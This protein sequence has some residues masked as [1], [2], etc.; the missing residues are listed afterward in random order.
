EKRVNIRAQET[1]RTGQRQDRKERCLGDADAGIGGGELTL[2]SGDVRPALEQIGGQTGG[3]NRRLRIPIGRV[4]GW[5]S[6]GCRVDAGQ[7]GDG[8]FQLS[9]ALRERGGLRLSRCQLR[10]GAR[11]VQLIADAAVKPATHESYLLVSEINGAFDDGDFRV[12][13]AQR[14]VVLGDIGLQR[15]QH[16]IKSRQR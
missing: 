1:A 9:T 11:H 12:E 15:Y 13:R 8:V 4:D 2:G 6:K 10:L 5:K 14:E 7:N 16:I 3:N